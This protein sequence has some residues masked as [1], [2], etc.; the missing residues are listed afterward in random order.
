[1]VCP[2]FML[3]IALALGFLPGVRE[4]Q[5]A[6]WLGPSI[7]EILL[8]GGSLAMFLLLYLLSLRRLINGPASS[9]RRW[10]AVLVIWTLIGNAML[11]PFP[12]RALANNSL[13]RS[14]LRGAAELPRW[15]AR[16]K[17]CSKGVR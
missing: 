9:R 6:S 12:P 4:G 2:F 11:I 10:V 14:P 8:F 13:Q 1:M 7:S 17:V 15:A 3:C 16:C 5:P